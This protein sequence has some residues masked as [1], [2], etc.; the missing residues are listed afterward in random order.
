[1]SCAYGI[2]LTLA[3]SAAPVVEPQQVPPAPCGVVFVVGGVGG[4]DPLGPSSHWALPKAGVPHELRDF[5][6]THGV[7]HPL[8]DL[9]DIRHV[10]AKA[11]ELADLVRAV[12]AADPDRPIYLMGHSGGTGICLAAAERLPTA[13][14]ERIILLNAAVSPTLDLRPALRATRCEIVSFYSTLD[15][16][17]LGCGTWKFGTMDRVYTQSSGRTGFV[18]PAD[19]DDEGRALYARLVQI[20]CSVADV[21]YMTAGAHHSYVM[22]R[23]LGVRVAPWLKP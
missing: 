5:D 10:N 14:V 4:V 21:P 12:K 20:P 19:L 22:P 17:V 23:F 2:A 1:M 8:R 9:Q 11:D 3:V 6:W 15:T 7:G 13:T 16:L 18:I